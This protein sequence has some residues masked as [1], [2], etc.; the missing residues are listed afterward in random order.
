MSADPYNLLLDEYEAK[1]PARPQ[2]GGTRSRV[3]EHAR[4]M[5][6]PMNLVDA[7]LGQESGWSHRGRGGRV[8]VSPKGARGLFQVMPETGKQLGYDNL[9]D[10]DQ[11]IQAGLTYLKQGLEESG[12]D[13]TYALTRY[14]GGPGAA[15]QYRQTGRVPKTSDG[16]ITTDRYVAN[17]QR[18]AG[19]QQS[20]PY[21]ALLDD[22]EKASAQP[23]TTVP[24]PRQSPQ[25]V[26]TPARRGA[27]ASAPP[28]PDPLS[29]FWD[30]EPRV[31]YTGA[32]RGQKARDVGGEK[33][34]PAIT[35][36]TGAATPTLR[37]RLRPAQTDEAA[38]D[39]AYYERLPEEAKRPSLGWR[40][41]DVDFN[42]PAQL[43]AARLKNEEDTQRA[44]AEAARIAEVPL[45]AQARTL[46][47]NTLRS[48]AEIPAGV[49]DTV[50]T[51][52]YEVDKRAF[53]SKK[54]RADY[55][56]SELTK[57]IR[58][59]TKG[60]LPADER[61]AGTFTF[62]TLPQAAGSALGIAGPGA[63]T[64]WIKNARYVVP[65][66]LGVT[67]GFSEGYNDAKRAGASDDDALKS[68]LLN[69]GMGASEVITAAPWIGRLNR[70]TR[71]AFGRAMARSG[72]ESV[73]EAT[74]TALR[75]PSIRQAVLREMGQEGL[76]EASQTAFGNL[77]ANTIVGY[78]PERRTLEGVPSAA[79]AG[80]LVGGGMSAA[81]I[82]A[83]RAANRRPEAAG[84]KPRPTIPDEIPVST[85]AA[86]RLVKRYQHRDF[87][88]VTEAENQAGT[89]RG[90][91]RVVD[92]EGAE[93]L[94]QRPNG[95]GQGN[96]LAVPVRTREDVARAE[97][98]GQTRP[99]VLP[100]TEAEVAANP[101][102]A[103]AGRLDAALAGRS[104][105]AETPAQKRERE[106]QAAPPESAPPPSTGGGVQAENVKALPARSAPNVEGAPARAEAQEAQASRE[107]ALEGGLTL[108][109]LSDGRVALEGSDFMRLGTFRSRAE[110]LESAEYITR[111]TR[112]ILK[113]NI[114]T[115]KPTSPK[116]LRDYLE[117]V[118]TLRSRFNEGLKQ[119]LQL[120]PRE[121]DAVTTVFDSLDE[122]L[123]KF[124]LP[125]GS[126]LGRVARVESGGE[127]GEGSLYQKDAAPVFY[128]QARKVVDSIPQERMTPEQLR[129]ALTKG[130]VKADELKWTGL[131]D[132]IA[133]KGRS[134]TKSEVS[135]FLEENE[136]RVEE[137]VKGEPA[138]NR[139]EVET[140]LDEINAA[141]EKLGERRYALERRRRDPLD[142]ATPEQLKAEG[143]RIDGEAKPL[144][145]ERVRLQ[146]QLRKSAETK[147]SQYTLPGAKEGSYRELLLTLPTKRSG[148]PADAK[149]QVE[150]WTTSDGVE[151]TAYNVHSDSMGNLGSGTTEAEAWIWAR[152]NAEYQNKQGASVYKSSHFDEPN[153]L[154][155]V[156][157]N[158]RTDAEG[159]K[160]LFI[161][162]IQSDFAQSLRKEK[163]KLVREVDANFEKIVEKL[164]KNGKINVI[165]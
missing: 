20:D 77:V 89:G 141:M 23:E 37:A 47:G 16:L 36:A 97:E 163:Q 125:R 108:L 83:E 17:I 55:F 144:H 15:R 19:V 117:F 154:A 94:I 165:C 31:S 1:P 96:A 33:I 115:G 12:G 88:E 157:F 103:Q 66:F 129:A 159:R 164:R 91:V 155:H 53:N 69:G 114:E 139:E 128:S 120:R 4:R 8:K 41:G 149:I 21:S 76:Q 137:V 73:E 71:G 2:G 58:E 126:L 44:E 122:G 34:A 92:A 124:D 151:Q 158:E 90:R 127:A 59:G 11:N 79:L 80:A 27:R 75:D 104:V 133:S 99:A 148:L 51:L 10:E 68:A 78:D 109:N 116:A 28:R 56:T 5:G 52:A 35:T 39:R 24:P 50:G 65:A 87:G 156:R 85:P 160:T 70:A 121:A 84:L 9:D 32:R 113:T 106:A 98:Y 7:V 146:S 105:T 74:Q 123:T 40:P 82:G 48:V 67:S 72:A 111:R 14:H 42:D 60:V 143:E 93:H 61:L 57:R 132:Y 162:E 49:L 18:K 81:T 150:K 130:G 161:E 38:K 62:E 3:E 136:V 22:F 26:A 142:D 107:E 45:S 29:R 46:A 54:E 112:D 135:R 140:R 131:D 86:P 63:A 152:K 25:P 64:S 101:Y 102:R 118:E 95:R 100:D 147:F 13:T 30:F 145:E 134:V 6:V 110:A 119:H 43:R 153:V 138:A